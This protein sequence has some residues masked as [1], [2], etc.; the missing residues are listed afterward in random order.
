MPGDLSSK[1]KIQTPVGGLVGI[2]RAGNIAHPEEYS[3]GPPSAG[4][5]RENPGSLPSRGI[6]ALVAQPPAPSPPERALFPGQNRSRK[7]SSFPNLSQQA[8]ENIVII[9]IW[10]GLTRSE[11]G[12]DHFDYIMKTGALFYR[13]QKG[14]QGVLVSRRIKEGYAE[15]LSLSLWDSMES[16]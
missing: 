10:N 9:R 3:L 8:R 13:P 5:A 11:D 2:L 1:R 4:H 12:N 14:C 16:I 7:M 6:R 15:Y